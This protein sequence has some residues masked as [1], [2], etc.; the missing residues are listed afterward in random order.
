MG[1][2]SLNELEARADAAGIDLSQIDLDSIQLPPG[3][4]FGIIRSVFMIK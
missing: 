1:E 2:I 3:D 4:N